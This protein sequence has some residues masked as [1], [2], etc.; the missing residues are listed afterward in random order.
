MFKITGTAHDFKSMTPEEKNDFLNR[1]TKAVHRED[2]LQYGNSHIFYS[3]ANK[4]ASVV[5]SYILSY[6]FLRFTE[7]IQRLFVPKFYHERKGKNFFKCLLYIGEK[8]RLM[9]DIFMKM[10]LHSV[11][12]YMN[13]K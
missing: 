8:K 9:K 12:D 1:L 13:T 7:K 2:E 4:S 6:A 3:G 10:E 11:E 5:L